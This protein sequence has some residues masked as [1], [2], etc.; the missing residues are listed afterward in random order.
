LTW[1]DTES[2]ALKHST[3]T[4]TSNAAITSSWNGGYVYTITPTSNLSAGTYYVSASVKDIHGFRV[5]S[6]SMS[7]TIVQATTGSLTT[8][9]TFYVI[10]S[11]TS[12]AFVYT[13]TNGRTGTRGDLGVTYSPQYNSAAVASFTSSNALVGVTKGGFLSVGNVSGSGFTFDA[14]N[15]I[16]SN[17][18]WRDQYGNI[19]GPTQISINVAINNAPTVT[20]TNAGSTTLNTNVARTSG[21]PT[22]STITFTD[23]ESDSLNH[24]TFTFTSPSGQ[25]SASRSGN[26]WLVNPINNLSASVYQMTASIKDIHG[27]RVGVATNTFDIIKAKIGSFTQPSLFIVE[28][29]L[30]GAGV[31]TQS[32][33]SGSAYTLSVSYSPNYGS[34]IATN[35]SASGDAGYVFVHPTSGVVTIYKNLSGSAVQNGASLTPT[36]TWNDQYGNLGSQSLSVSVVDNQAATATFTDLTANWI[37]DPVAS[38]VGLVSASITDPEVQIVSMS[39]SGTD[40]GSLVAVPVRFDSSSYV[41]KSATTLSPATYLY[42][43][44]IHDNYGN[45]TSYNRSIV[46]TAPVSNPQLYIYLANHGSNAALGSSYLSVMGASTVNGNTPPQVTALTATSGSFF[47]QLIE[48]GKLGNT[49]LILPGAKVGNLVASAVATGSVEDVVEN[50]G[51]FAASLTGQLIVVFPSGSVELNPLPTS[52][53]DEFAGSVLH[54][55]AM[56]VQS[57]GGGWANTTVASTIHEIVLN[58]AVDGYTDWFV[59]GRTGYTTI[60]SNAEI[61]IRPTSGSAQV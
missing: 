16:T 13:S 30:S 60:S 36:I 3:L 23:A 47:K 6:S 1:T 45:V 25:L 27:F 33:G 58:S 53:T 7:F 12:G 38:G 35:F 42:S 18:T 54:Q 32:D 46:V 26:S 57:D 59:I 21:N 40:A 11:A 56:Q 5:G 28:S 49:G 41:I 31:T 8:N 10:E 39:L 19:G 48:G 2:N 50:I 52:M 17:I 44:S 9:G 29:A 22:L 37:G 61:R 4:L 55:Y 24:S 20:F 51:Q 34:Q 15:P 14:G 43:A